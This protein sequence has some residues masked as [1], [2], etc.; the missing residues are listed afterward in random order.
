MSTNP[1]REIRR[2]V[3]AF[4]LLAAFLFLCVVAQSY[5]GRVE[6]HDSQIAGCNRGSTHSHSVVG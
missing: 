2:V 3:I 6:I 5:Q 4:A 1:L